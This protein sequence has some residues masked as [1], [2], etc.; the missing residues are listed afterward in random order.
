MSSLATLPAITASYTRDEQVAIFTANGQS[1]LGIFGENVWFGKRMEIKK[2]ENQPIFGGCHFMCVFPKVEFRP[3]RYENI[4]IY[5]YIYTYNI[6]IHI[7]M[8]I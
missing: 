6:Y 5:I 2:P 1:L 7:Y 8:I 3:R 4:I